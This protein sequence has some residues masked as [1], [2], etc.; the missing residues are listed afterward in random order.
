MKRSKP[1]PK[2]SSPSLQPATPA[3]AVKASV[4]PLAQSLAQRVGPPPTPETEEL[5][6]QAR[7]LEE[8]R[9]RIL[10]LEQQE[11]QQEKQIQEAQRAA[12]RCWERVVAAE[13]HA[14]EAQQLAER[15]SRAAAWHS[16]EAKASAWLAAERETELRR[17][18]SANGEP[19]VLIIRVCP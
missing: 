16:Q 13:R 19:A 14:A 9:Q 3:P 8:R 10:Q 18:Q 5:A 7:Q 11:K 15:W 6:L 17:V 4:Q 12:A 2:P 1:S